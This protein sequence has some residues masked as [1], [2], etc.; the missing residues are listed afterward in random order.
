M[1]SRLIVTTA[2]SSVV[3]ALLLFVAAGTVKWLAG[4]V[5]LVT[6]HGCGLAMEITL[7]KRDPALLE[8]RL[9]SPIEREQKSW[10]KI[11][12]LLALVLFVVW[13][14]LIALDAVRYS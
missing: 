3:T 10:D 5:F 1:T 4:W 6:V 2:L 13:L 14:P 12:L 11:L 7:A 8:E 9:S